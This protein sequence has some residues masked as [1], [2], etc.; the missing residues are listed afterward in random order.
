MKKVK[1]LE[2]TQIDLIGKRFNGYDMIYDLDSKLFDIK[3][4]VTIKQSNDNSVIK[5]LNTNGEI[6]IM[7]AMN[8]LEKRLSIKN[9]LSITTPN[10]LNMKEYKEADIIHIH[11]FHNANMSL[12]FIKKIASEKKTIISLHD[13]WF[14]TGHCAYPLDCTLWKDGCKSCPNLD[15]IFSMRE[16]NCSDMWNLKKNIFDTIDVDIIVYSDWMLNLVKQSPIFKN[17]KRIHKISFGIDEKKFSN[18]SKE[19]ARKHYNIPEK[20]FVFFTRAQKGFKGTSYLLEALKQ[21]ENV[22]KEIIILTCDTTNLL[23]EVKDKFKIIDLGIIDDNEMSYAMN[24]CDV[25]L[26]PSIAESFGLMAI[27]AMVC[28]KPVVV[29]NNSALPFVTHAPECGYLVK[30]CDSK[31]LMKTLKNIIDNPKEVVK[32][33]KLAYSIVKK[34]YTLKMYN[35]KFNDLYSKIAKRKKE[36]KKYIIKYDD[37]ENVIQFK[38]ILNDFSVGIFGT[39]HPIVKELLYNTKNAK[40]IKKYNFNFSDEQMQNLIMEYTTKLKK[41][42]DKYGIQDLEAR[43]KIKLEKIIYFLIHNPKGIIRILKKQ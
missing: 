35:D 15:T 3:Q 30:N 21:W 31:D 9:I 41:L 8:S 26:M 34:E 33:G 25:F 7:E 29:F 22:K 2:V 27:E 18:V 4:A 11:Q 28:S 16:D 19:E 40:R 20:S 42:Y 32:R 24:A 5:M 17:Q 36:Y 6:K 12:P 10:L 23:D 1:V 39:S 13:P 37:S 38:F 43:K 14:F